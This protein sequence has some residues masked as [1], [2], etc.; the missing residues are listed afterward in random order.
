MNVSPLGTPLLSGPKV[1]PH[2]LFLLST[3]SFLYFHK[4]TNPF[5]RLPARTAFYFHIL[6]NPFSRKPFG[7]TIQ[8]KTPGCSP[9]PIQGLSVPSFRCLCRKSHA[10][11]NL[12][13][14]CSLFALF[15]FVFNTFRTLL[16]KHRGWGGYF[17][18]RTPAPPQRRILYIHNVLGRRH[19]TR[20]FERPGKRWIRHGTLI[21]SFKAGV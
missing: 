10:F 12:R 17:A 15:S 11:S 8:Y 19:T 16:P 6:T 14:L 20:V 7:F 3:L 21:R 13:T 18:S 5:F 9:H 1:Y 2:L 4:L